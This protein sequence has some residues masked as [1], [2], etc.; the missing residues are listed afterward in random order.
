MSFLFLLLVIL[1][2]LAGAVFS[3][4]WD[5][6]LS[7]REQEALVARRLA[8][9]TWM[10]GA[11]LGVLLVLVPNKPRALML[12]PLFFLTFGLGRW[13]RVKRKLR[14]DADVARMKRIN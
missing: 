14:E 2:A 7:R 12:T 11:L 5:R 6:S 1:G 4:L 3:P 13:W 8:Q 10:V 9:I